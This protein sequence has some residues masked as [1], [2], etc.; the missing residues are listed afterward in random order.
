M[1]AGPRLSSVNS[2]T[3]LDLREAWQLSSDALARAITRLAP[4]VHHAS[5]PF[6]DWYYGDAETARDVIT[7]WMGRASSE[8]HIGRALLLKG[9]DE[10]EP[11]LG[12]LI[13]MAGEALAECRAAD[14]LAF[15]EEL[16]GGAEADEVIGE[17]L[18]VARQLFPPVAPDAFYISRVVIDPARRGA[19]L[20]RALVEKTLERRRTKGFRR[21]RLDV[22]ADNEA[23]LRTYRALGFEVMETSESAAHGLRYLAM[24]TR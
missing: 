5:N 4:W 22:S 17:V 10:D 24:E 8:L 3:R 12:C 15:C 1:P 11:P 9:D 7:E 23:A 18:P 19:G 13:G 21:F 6:A 14:F 16:G 2:V 20:G